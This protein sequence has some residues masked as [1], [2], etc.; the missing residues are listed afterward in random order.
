M[1]DFDFG[2]NGNQATSEATV[3]QETNEDVTT[4]TTGNPADVINNDD[5]VDITNND[6]P[7][8]SENVEN[9]D[10]TA[11]DDQVEKLEEGTVI[12]F[13]DKKYTVDANGNVVD[14]NGK[15]FKEA[16]DVDAWIKSLDSQEVDDT[17]SNLIN[18]E[19]LQ[20]ILGVQIAD[21]D[22]KPIEFEN[23]A[24]GA[25][26]YIKAYVE[27]TKQ[28]IVNDTIDALYSKYPILENVINYYVANGNSLEGFNEVRDRSTIEL[29]TNNEAQC[30]AIIR[31]AWKEENRRG[32]V[33]NYI[34]YLKSQN[35]LG[36]TAH[37]ELQG[38]IAR[39][40]AYSEELARQAEEKEQAYIKE[41]K[42]YWGS[43]NKVVTVDKR[44]GKY[45]IPDTI[46][47]VKDGQ[48]ISA[49]PQDFFNYIYQV[50]KQGRSQYE[51]DLLAEATNSPQ[52]RMSNDLIAAFL[53]FTGG[54]YESLVNMAINEQKV[55]TIKIQSKQARKQTVKVTTPSTKKKEIDLGY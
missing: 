43:V 16:K 22:G 26:S 27:N 14:N 6:E 4:V 11:T 13:D 5:K 9:K 32:D 2:F 38:M 54:S 51:N 45:Q 47:R 37:D 41:Q 44:I 52:T 21:E 23:T 31:A 17:N 20:S 53:K 12:E 40:K 35:L 15:I 19:N 46:I 33:S 30:E 34:Q 42:E 25:A 10:T 29:D 24:E 7:K 1:P 48:R 55:K 3:T 50:D 49:T 8:D 36:A 28:Q 39:D 18:V